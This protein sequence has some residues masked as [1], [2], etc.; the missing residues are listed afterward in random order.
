MCNDFKSTVNLIV[1]SAFNWY[2]SNNLSDESQ[3]CPLLAYFFLVISGTM[4]L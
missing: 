2:L 1:N 4:K 3:E